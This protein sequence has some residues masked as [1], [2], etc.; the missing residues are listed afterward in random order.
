MRCEEL[1]DVVDSGRNPACFGASSHGIK[2]IGS[3][4]KLAAR[5]RKAMNRKKKSVVSHDFSRFCVFFN[6]F[7]Q[8]KIFFL[9]FRN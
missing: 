5:M 6:A 3:P 2:T 4:A 1:C 7:L 8:K 9:R